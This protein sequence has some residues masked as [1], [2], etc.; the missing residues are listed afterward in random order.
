MAICGILIGMVLG[1]G[2]VSGCGKQD[3]IKN[4]SYAKIY[5]FWHPPLTQSSGYEVFTL[6]DYTSESNDS[7]IGYSVKQT[8]VDPGHTL[9]APNPIKIDGKTIM[10]NQCGNY[11]ITINVNG[12]MTRLT[13]L[14]Y[15]G[16]RTL[17]LARGFGWSMYISR[18]NWK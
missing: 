1:G 4:S 8:A 18:D 11:D 7:G 6:S 14:R 10:T 3:D 5:V 9:L 15:S 17:P 13:G 2:I 16:E 12:T